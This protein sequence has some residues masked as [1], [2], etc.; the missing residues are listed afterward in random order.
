MTFSGIV[1][2]VL[3]RGWQ[4][5][6][7]P[8]TPRPD[9]QG[10]LSRLATR[11]C[12]RAAVG[13]AVLTSREA[14]HIFGAA[15]ARHGIQP[16][17]VRVENRSRKSLRLQTVRIDP[18]YFTPLEA[19]AACHF[20]ILRRLSTFGLLGWFLAPLLLLVPLKLIT[21]AR[22]NRRMDAIFRRLGFR[23]APIE[24]GRAAEGFVFTT[25]DLGTKSVHVRLLP[26]GPLD[27]TEPDETPLDS[28][29][30]DF[31]IP[32]QGIS[33][34][35][36]GRDFA[37]L[38]PPHAVRPCT[39]DELIAALATMPA[40]TTNASADGTG[41]PVNLVVIGPFEP[42]LA[43]FA[44]RWDESETI[45]LATCWK[46]VK[47][48]LLGE[49]YRYSPVSPLYLF[50]RH[51]DFALQRIRESINERLH[52]RLWLTPLTFANSPVWIGQVSRDIGVRF[53]TKAW[54]LTTHRIDPDVDEA[55]DYVLEDLL[56]AGRVAAAGYLGGVGECAVDKPRHN[57]TGDPYFTD[58][59]RVAI[60]LRQ[61][62]PPLDPSST[63]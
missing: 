5:F 28:V 4:F 8:Y 37:T 15:L 10:F 14:E 2:R 45:T 61:T 39:R 56:A 18:R 36:R 51:Q 48:F 1:G 58:G 62:A 40:A 25:I 29:D 42:L 9:E 22:A 53:T 30:F 3:H 23:L 13:V 7:T 44:S 6:I 12:E 32:V 35:Y 31:T 41:D 50:G 24:A 52:L 26:I 20:S 38:V 34:D 11:E 27:V 54:N 63:A 47:A 16:V 59:K 46:T 55:R 21:A 43:A 60:L 19:A 57:L 17:Y 33:A 49:N